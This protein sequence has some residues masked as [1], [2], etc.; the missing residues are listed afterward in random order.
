MESCSSGCPGWWWYYG[1][2]ANQILS[3]AQRNSARVLTAD[4]YPG[5]GGY[6]F[7]SVMIGGSIG[8]HHGG[9][10]ARLRGFVDLHTHP[11]SNLG[12]GGK[13]VYGGVDVGSLL[14][15][16]PD[17]HHDVRATSMQQALGHDNST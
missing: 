11:L 3:E 6:C 8:A 2:D 16:D 15:A 12:F 7:A 17:C 13:L 10:A 9:V 4:T 14:P 1:Q 5:C